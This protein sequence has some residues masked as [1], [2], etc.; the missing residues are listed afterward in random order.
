MQSNPIP[1]I[2]SVMV[3]FHIFGSTEKKKGSDTIHLICSVDLIDS[4][5]SPTF[6][7]G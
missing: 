6:Q 7:A 5:A 3:R 2:S 1:P 4:R